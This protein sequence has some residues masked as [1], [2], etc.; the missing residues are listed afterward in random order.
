MDGLTI[1]VGAVNLFDEYPDKRNSD[2][3]ALQF[4]TGDNGYVSQY[5]SFSPFG[6]NG[7]YY[8]GKVAYRF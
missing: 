7:G 8:Y 1:T 4:N 2:Y 6:I 5:P 3:R